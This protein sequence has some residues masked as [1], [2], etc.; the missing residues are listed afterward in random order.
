MISKIFREH[1][2][3]N[4]FIESYNDTKCLNDKYINAYCRTDIFIVSDNDM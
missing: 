2:N 1:K 3:W 4:F